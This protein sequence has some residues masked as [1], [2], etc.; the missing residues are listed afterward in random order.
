MPKRRD[1]VSKPIRKTA[2]SAESRRSAAPPRPPMG[3]PG[4][5]VPL[6]YAL[7]CV[8][9]FR[10]FVLGP[11]LVLGTDTQALSYFARN[12]YTTFV[13]QFGS[14][15]LW[16]PLLFGGLPFVDGMHGDI[17][18]PPSLALFFMD[19]A[20]YWGWK[21]VLHVFMAGIFTYLWLRELG[22]RR[23]TAF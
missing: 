3:F 4:W 23:E 19:T 13:R 1:T 6:V 17:F 5:A 21:M 15:P 22:L 12:F 11:D 8:I 20:Q 7:V 18:Y 2:A 16:D 9:I 10:E 14:F